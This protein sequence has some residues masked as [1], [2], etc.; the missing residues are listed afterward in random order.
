MTDLFLLMLQTIAGSSESWE[1]AKSVMLALITIASLW[2]A[3]TVFTLRDAVRD[4]STTV[5]GVD[6]LN[7]KMKMVE[8]RLGKIEERNLK[9]DAIAQLEREQYDGPERREAIRRMRDHLLLP[10]IPPIRERGP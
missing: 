5:V 3:R 8:M 1:V 7:A 10:D 9:I 6:G 4:L 2:T